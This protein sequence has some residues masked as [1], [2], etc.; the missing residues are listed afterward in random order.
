MS[1]SATQVKGKGFAVATGLLAIAALAW[2]F[3]F[4]DA[5]VIDSLRERWEEIFGIEWF[6]DTKWRYLPILFLTT[7]APTFVLGGVAAA[8]FVRFY[9]LNFSTIHHANLRELAK[10]RDA[11]QQSLSS[12]DTIEREYKGKLDSY[13]QLQKQLEELQ[14]VKEI[15]TEDLRKKLSA[16]AAASRFSAWFQRVIGFLVGIL[17]SLLAAYLWEMLRAI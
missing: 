12:I 6:K 4:S 17:S 7:F 10:A 9:N 14:S 1:E 2:L 3:Y 16:I 13:E 15:D 11:L 5:L 8:L